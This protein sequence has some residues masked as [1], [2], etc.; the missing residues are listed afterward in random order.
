M[1]NKIAFYDLVDYCNRNS[2]DNQ[3]YL[4]SL[5]E[6]YTSPPTRIIEAVQPE[7]NTLKM[8]LKSWANNDLFNILDSGSCAKGTAI[9][10]SSDI[11]YLVSLKSEFYED[12]GGL[13]V[14]YRSLHDELLK[15]YGKENIRVQN[16]SFRINIS[17]LEVDITPARKHKGNTNDHSLFISK[18]Q[19]WQKTNIQ[20]H[21]N[22]VSKSGRTKE[23][24]L[25]KIWRELNK[26]DF[27]SIYLE[28]LIIQQIL[29][30][31]SASD[32]A[33]SSNF[34]Y[35]LEELSKEENGALN[36]RIIDPANSNNI[37]S[38]LL[39]NDEK[40]KIIRKV[41]ESLKSFEEQGYWKH[42]I[43]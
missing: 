31:K 24:K 16:V 29:L 41:K 38:E 3:N 13:N 7:L 1:Q 36:K 6:K 26:L 19:T 37:L 28:Y 12:E 27:P 23:I 10:L 21:I 40:N 42:V 32:D 8:L 22:D 39:T 2:T 11:D 30:G 5:L 4:K 20:T 34:K 17:N 35:I 25:L 43:W 15:N 9:K 14:I 18:L 33:L